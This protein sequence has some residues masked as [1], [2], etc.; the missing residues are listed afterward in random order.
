MAFLSGLRRRDPLEETMA[1]VE[2]A[3]QREGT[4]VSRR[5]VRGALGMPR[6][7]PNAGSRVSP[8]ALD[9]IRAQPAPQRPA[10]SPVIVEIDGLGRVEMGPEFASMSPEE[11]QATVAEIVASR[12]PPQ[13]V[14]GVGQVTAM[15]QA[16]DP[17][18][19]W[20]RG[21]VET[22]TGALQGGGR[23]FDNAAELAQGAYNQTLGRVLGRSDSATRANQAG[24]GFQG[25]AD[26]LP[27]GNAAGR[28]GGE[29][30]ASAL[31]TRGVGGP[32]RQGAASGALMSEADDTGG[33]MRDIA[34]GGAGGFIGDRIM[35]GVAGA[36][37]PTVQPGARELANRGVRMTPGQVVGGRAQ[38]V[39]DMA[40]SFPYVGGAI[41]QGR[42]QSFEDFNRAAVR[43]VAEAYNSVGGVRPIAIPDQP[44]R[45]AVAAVGNQLSQR[46]DDL[47]PR[48]S[49]LPDR[50]LADDIT[51]A[52]DILNSGDLSERA[53]GQFRQI[54]MTQ[55][56]PH[57]S[58][59]GAIPGPAYRQ[60]ERRL[61]ERIARFS[62]DQTA[63]GQAM[64][65][66]L[67]NIQQAFQGA[68][69]R[70]NPRHAEELAAL[71]SGWSNLVRVEAAAGSS[72]AQGGIFSP[73]QFRSAVRGADNSVR[74][75][76][77]ARGEARMQELADAADEILPRSYPDSG[78]AGRLNISPARPE[79]WGGLLGR[80]LYGPG[81]QQNISNFLLRPRGPAAEATANAIRSLPA[82]QLGAFGLQQLFGIPIG[83]VP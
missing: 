64:A 73:A 57:L 43:E 45:R 65:E 44:G 46:Y 9:P 39:E 24:Q 23:V 25:L 75:R 37:A 14:R 52:A 60:I 66:G 3:R 55:V 47:V 20:G 70:S 4:P 82:P 68:L 32:I 21:G 12:G 51:Q 38:T 13:E 33:F 28:F 53:A 26:Q 78:T 56:Q 67:R 61:G 18:N 81:T 50:Q 35:R 5:D 62:R 29:V 2:A 31:L 40:T 74:R 27:E 16:N 77:Y 80:G 30:A 1:F 7:Q 54:L 71:N 8:S 59:S 79:F 48:L 41:E 76:A 15:P 6:P 49:L 22:I 10:G 58:G 69:Q 72:G 83:S 19:Q 36:I 17:L 11:Q 42:R 63:D 34:L